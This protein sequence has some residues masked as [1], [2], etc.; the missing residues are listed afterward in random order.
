MARTPS[1]NN[2]GYYEVTTQEQAPQAYD[3][4]TGFLSGGGA[5]TVVR[6]YRD[7]GALAYTEQVNPDGSRALVGTVGNEV[8]Q[9]QSGDIATPQGAG[10]KR[11][12][13]EILS[14]SDL[15][16]P[17]SHVTPGDV[18]TQVTNDPY[19]TLHTIIN[20]S[21][22]L[23]PLGHP[24]V[25]GGAVGQTIEDVGTG[26]K[27]LPQGV[28]DFITNDTAVGPGWTNGQP[29]GQTPSGGGSGGAGSPGPL[30]SLPAVKEA[31]DFA[32]Q[33]LAERDAARAAGPRP[34]PQATASTI[35][36]AS[37]PFL[38]PAAT[39]QGNTQITATPTARATVGP[40][41][42]MSVGSISAGSVSANQIDP[43]SM[44]IS[45]EG[46][47]RDAEKRALALAEGAANGTAPSRAEALLRKGIDEG[48]GAQYGIAAALQGRNPGQALR[49]ASIGAANVTAK[50]AADMAA[51]R[52]DEMAT[53]RRDFLAG[54]GQLRTG[55]I[56]V[57]KANQSTALQANL[58]NLSA[59]TQA[60]IASL[61]AAT[62]TAKANLAAQVAAGQANLA[63]QTQIQ[64]GQLQADMQKAH[65]DAWNELQG[66]IASGQLS[67]DSFKATLQA[68]TDLSRANIDSLTRILTTN[69]T[70]A[71][72]TSIENTKAA[73]NSRQLDDLLQSSYGDQIIKALGLPIDAAK[74][75][76]DNA[77]RNRAGDQTFW[78][79][80]IGTGAKLLFA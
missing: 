62:E 14:A 45:I 28:Q 38:G 69:S 29:G 9:G 50:S 79:S 43:H 49:Q 54:A 20:D 4:A 25:K 26:K 57:Q 24:F 41:G 33:L 17:V 13:G 80:L 58:G 27:T 21:E 70:N 19:G 31:D 10:F 51:L 6:T 42:S 64:L 71:T 66:K 75:D 15:A 3:P 23:D 52:A 56:D 77:I 40:A 2:P 35:D 8:P 55:D 78:A 11:D 74:Q 72:N 47:G 60:K 61:Q 32:K 39:Y 7:D 73:I 30:S 67:L 44:D 22:K 48:V 68:N 36:P 1:S 18:A 63:A 34:V 76:I 37:V 16:N 46:E 12:T 53:A 59:D 5:V 65:D